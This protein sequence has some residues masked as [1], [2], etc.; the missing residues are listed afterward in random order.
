MN[1]VICVGVLVDNPVIKE[2]KA[3]YQVSFRVATIEDDMLAVSPTYLN[4]VAYKEVAYHIYKRIDKGSPVI[5]RG[6][7]LYNQKANSNYVRVL[8][9][10][11]LKKDEKAVFMNMDEFMEIYQPE[12]VLKNLQKEIKESKLNDKRNNDS[13]SG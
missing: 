2:T 7:V 4:C 8:Y 11:N 6:R 3:G 13:E 1:I 5:L 12:N 9:I 10:M